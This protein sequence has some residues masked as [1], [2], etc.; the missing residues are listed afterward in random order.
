MPPPVD[1]ETLGYVAAHAGVVLEVDAYD[2]AQRVAS[3]ERRGNRP[4]EVVILEPQHAKVRE[5]GELGRYGAGQAVIF[6]LDLLKFWHAAP[7]VAGDVALESVVREVELGEVREAFAEPPGYG[8]AK[9]P[10][11]EVELAEMAE[12]AQHVEG[13]ERAFDVEIAEVYVGHCEVPR[14]LAGRGLR[15]DH[16]AVTRLRRLLCALRL[17]ETAARDVVPCAPRV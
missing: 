4:L 5:G 12:A 17:R 16:R 8:A 14:L 11:V 7:R 6:Q 3:A 9:A 1:D 15:G 10:A 2:A 13:R